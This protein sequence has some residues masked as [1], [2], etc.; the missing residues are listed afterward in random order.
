MK[1]STEKLR[2]ILVART[3]IFKLLKSK[4]PF[5][6]NDFSKI[7]EDILI[8]TKF[9]EQSTNKKNKGPEL[10]VCPPIAAEKT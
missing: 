3:L 6:R 10:L 5:L 8:M 9:Y 4:K 7:V 2:S 1:I